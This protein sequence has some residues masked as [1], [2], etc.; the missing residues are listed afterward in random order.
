MNFFDFCQKKFMFRQSL[1]TI[2]KSSRRTFFW[3]SKPAETVAAVAPTLP[4]AD[5][6]VLDQILPNLVPEFVQEVAKTPVLTAITQFGDLQSIGLAQS[7]LFGT[8][9]TLFEY[10]HVLTGLPWYF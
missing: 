2:Q 8:A 3:S 10:S 4:L 9:Q 5:S 6:P 7:G 1:L